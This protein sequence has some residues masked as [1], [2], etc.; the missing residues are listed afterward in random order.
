MWKKRKKTEK[1]IKTSLNCVQSLQKEIRVNWLAYVTEES[2]ALATVL[3]V[4]GIYKVS[5]ASLSDSKRRMNL[6]ICFSKRISG[7]EFMK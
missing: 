6:G 7:Y 1:K 2:R 4:R 5:S 3:A